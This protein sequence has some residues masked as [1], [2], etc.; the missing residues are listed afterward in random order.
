MNLYFLNIHQSCISS[1]SKGILD[2]GAGVLIVFEESTVDKT[3]ETS[4]DT[5]QNMGKV[6]DAL[7][8]KAKRLT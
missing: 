1:Y 4:L 3:Y 2:Q 6:V 8:N 7:Y 5:I